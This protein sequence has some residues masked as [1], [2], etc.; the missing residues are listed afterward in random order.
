[1]YPAPNFDPYPA[2][3][4]VK[5][6]YKT[7]KG[8]ADCLITTTDGR[9]LVLPT[10]AGGVFNP[11][12]EVQEIE[13]ASRLG[14]MV[15]LDTY[16]SVRKPIIQ[17]DFRQ[18]NPTLI[19]MKLGQEFQVG[20]NVASRVFSNGFLVTRNTY[21]AAT[22]GLEGFGMPADQTGSVAFVLN[23]DE[24]VTA[25]TRTAFSGF[26]PASANTFAQG[27]DGAMQFSNN[28]IGRYVAYDFPHTLASALRLTEVAFNNFSMQLMTIMTDRSVLHWTFPSV[29]VQVEEG[30]I[31]LVEPD[32]QISFRVQDDG[33]S[34]LP[35]SVVYRGTAQLRRCA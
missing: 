18:K 13:G 27:A 3:D 32:M 15:T 9:R 20:S 21:A 28:L 31:N 2:T 25:L 33:S 29:S 19:G 12:Q 11:G 10:A 6:L 26:N 8:L 4:M 1:M 24:T 5:Q 17:L 30:D 14:E 34:C 16:T 7:I 22:T 35:Y 23:D